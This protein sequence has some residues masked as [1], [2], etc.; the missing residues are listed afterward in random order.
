MRIDRARTKAGR[1]D[2]DA[3]LDA[4]QGLVSGRWSLVDVFEQGG[5]RLLVA[6]ENEPEPPPEVRLSQRE[7]QVVAYAVMGQSQKLIAYTLG[8]SIASVSAHLT[9]ACRKLGVASRV[10]LAAVLGWGKTVE[11]ASRVAPIVE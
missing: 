8:L 5:R 6:R 2:A 11:P 10:Q 7:R 4:W 9:S 3:A 1:A